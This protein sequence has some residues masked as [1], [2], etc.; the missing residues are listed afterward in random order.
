MLALQ[1]REQKGWFVLVPYREQLNLCCGDAEGP[2]LSASI[3]RHQQ[4]EMTP[5]SP[6][7][8]IP[9]SFPAWNPAPC[10]L[11]RDASLSL[12]V[13]HGPALGAFHPWREEEAKLCLC[14]IF[15]V[16]TQH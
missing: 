14:P 13:G 16:Q 9:C 1:G 2:L 11:Q 7:G 10:P 15:P 12:V 4:G 3:K 8:I 6:R 5:S